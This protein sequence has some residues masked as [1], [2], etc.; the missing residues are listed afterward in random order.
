MTRTVLVTGGAGYI[1]SHACKAL[2]QVGYRPVAY[3]SLV[4]GHADAVKWGQLEQGDIRDRARLEAV[5]RT[6]DVAAVMHF[7]AFA[8]V[9]ESVSDPARY[10]DNNVGGSLSLLE[11]MRATGVT[12]LVFSSTCATYGTPVQLPI[13]ETTPQAPINPYGRTKLV[14]EGMISDF[15]RAYGLQA[16]CLRY[17]NA[18]GADPDGEIGERHDPETHAIPLALRAAYGTG[19]AFSIFGTDYDTP[20]GTAVRDY[21]HVQDLA[22]AHVKALEWLAAQGGV[23]VAEAF[24]LGTGEGVSVRALVASVARVTGRHFATVDAPRRAGDPPVLVASA[25]KAETMLGWRAH[26]RDIDAIIATA[27]PWF[28]P[29]T[30]AWS[31]Q[32]GRA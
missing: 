17:F 1:G 21:I 30:A 25:A 2:A 3:D 7:A 16:S 27:E 31:P 8:Y 9:G 28:R 11:A 22:E 19:P 4:H 18:A 26:F 5:I 24:N 10:Y 20:D 12:R 23:G 32:Q 14:V 6:H 15:T 29:V 13:D